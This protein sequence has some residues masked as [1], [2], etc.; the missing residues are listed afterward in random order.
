M[1]PPGPLPHRY[2]ATIPKPAGR[3]SPRNPSPLWISPLSIDRREMDL[4]ALVRGLVDEYQRVTERH[5]VGFECEPTSI[6]GSWDGRRLERA[7]S[8]LLA[9]AVKYS[10][11][12]GRIDVAMQI[13]GSMVQIALSADQTSAIVGL[14]GGMI[15]YLDGRAANQVAMLE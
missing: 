4:A 14:V 12:G 15:A 5:T 11:D 1:F 10:P 9:N 6:V 2:P 3:I 8:N 13:D 7:F